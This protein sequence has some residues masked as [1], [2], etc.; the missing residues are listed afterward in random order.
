MNETLLDKLNRLKRERNAV[1]LAHNYQ[2]DE[3]QDAADYVGDSLGLSRQA[4]TEFS[5]FLAIPVMFAAT[6]YDLV[7][8]WDHLSADSVG[9]FAV[10]FVAAF[11]SALAAIRFLLRFVSTHDFRPFAWYRIGFGLLVLVTLM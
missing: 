6:T 7:K 10:G 5:F 9:V 8:S 4:A 1:I 11:L 2:R 3:V